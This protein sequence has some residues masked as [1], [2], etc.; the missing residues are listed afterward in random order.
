MFLLDMGHQAPR[1]QDTRSH[2]L[3]GLGRAHP[4]VRG[5]EL[6]WAFRGA[7]PRAS[8]VSGV[9]AARLGRGL[10]LGLGRGLRMGLGMGALW[11]LSPVWLL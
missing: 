10:G 8:G 11:A 1:G 4:W 7:L 3:G 2:R 5:D 6:S 9:W